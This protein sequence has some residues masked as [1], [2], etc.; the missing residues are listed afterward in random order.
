MIPL[1]FFC[2]IF[3]LNEIILDFLLHLKFIRAILNLVSG[4]HTKRT[5]RKTNQMPV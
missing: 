4:T 5:Q 1:L 2:S 3:I